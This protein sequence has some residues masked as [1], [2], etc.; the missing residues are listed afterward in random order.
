MAKKHVVRL[1]DMTIVG[2]KPD[3]TMTSCFDGSTCECRLDRQICHDSRHGLD[4]VCSKG[5]V[6]LKEEF[7]MGEYILDK[8]SREECWS[9]T[10]PK[11]KTCVIGAS[12]GFQTVKE[13]ELCLNGTDGRLGICR[14]GAIFDFSTPL[15]RFTLNGLEC[16]RCPRC[17]Q[18]NGSPPTHL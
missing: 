2:N 8:L 10:L 15:M 5:L 12:C 16:E 14:C 18:P 13:D 3:P 4:Y 17:Q 1:R 11:P 7:L 9:P 6:F